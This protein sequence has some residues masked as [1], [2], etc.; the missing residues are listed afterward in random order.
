MVIDILDE[1]RVALYHLATELSLTSP[2]LDPDL[3]CEKA[4][5]MSYH[6]PSRLIKGVSELVSGYILFRNVVMPPCFIGTTPASNKE[7][8]GEKTML[9]CIQAI[10]MHCL[11]DMVA[12]EAEG[13]G[14][15]F[16]D[17]VP[18]KAMVEQQTSLGSTKELEIHTEQAFS[19]MRPDF[20]GLACLRG[21]PNALT[22]VLPV[23]AIPADMHPLL[24][25][26]LWTIGV[27]L[28]FRLEGVPGDMRGPVSIIKD[29]VDS[30]VPFFRFDQDLMVG[31]TDE[32][33]EACRKIV[34]IYYEKR[35]SVCLQP[36]DILFVDNRR[37]VH[38]RSPFMP[39]FDGDDRFLVR[40]FGIKSLKGQRMIRKE[41]S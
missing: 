9:S 31:L 6:V 3:F 21:D 29:G 37:A 2:S 18:S 39:R 4:K 25:Q 13:E 30:P 26:P 33:E 16:Q 1:E 5:A 24:R 7:H 14:Y 10:L 36:G 32:A 23:S 22:Y 19:E 8:V 11:G 12:Y 41:E 28:S 27:D 20:L 35:S 38:G 34:D 17:I 15:L 40:T